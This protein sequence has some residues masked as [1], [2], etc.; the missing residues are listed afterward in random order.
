MGICVSNIATDMVR[1]G[2]KICFRPPKVC[3]C[4]SFV[5]WT[6]YRKPYRNLVEYVDSSKRSIWFVPQNADEGN[7][8]KLQPGN[9]ACDSLHGPL[10]IALEAVVSVVVG[11][12]VS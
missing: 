4:P 8:N 12:V 6:F 5:L 3:F 11:V 7:M 1:D 9:R 10:R 2:R